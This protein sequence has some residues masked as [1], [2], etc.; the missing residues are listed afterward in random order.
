MSSLPRSY[1]PCLCG[2]PECKRCFPS[3]SHEDYTRDP[4]EDAC[5]DIQMACW[6]F[7][8]AIARCESSSRLAFI[9]GMLAESRKRL[10]LVIIAVGSKQAELDKATP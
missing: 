6:A 3:A 10:D 4:A 7:Q 5:Y 9:D 2:D 1:E 8:T